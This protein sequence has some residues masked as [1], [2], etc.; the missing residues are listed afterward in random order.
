MNIAYIPCTSPSEL[1]LHLGQYPSHPR[2]EV[3][4][5]H[6]PTPSCNLT[7]AAQNWLVSGKA[8]TLYIPH[9]AFSVLMNITL[10]DSFKSVSELQIIIFK[11]FTPSIRTHHVTT[12]QYIYNFGWANNVAITYS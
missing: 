9:G 4:L 10:K 3:L 7:C 1:G 2:R 6:H 5:L 11:A 8:D 12:N